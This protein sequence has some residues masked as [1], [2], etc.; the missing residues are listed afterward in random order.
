MSSNFNIKIIPSHSTFCCAHT[1]FNE[2]EIPIL[3]EAPYVDPRNE[4]SLEER[5][6]K[7]VEYA[8]NMSGGNFD[9]S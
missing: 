7:S 6:I 8:I 3:D 4:L 2:L 1:C 9:G 5:F